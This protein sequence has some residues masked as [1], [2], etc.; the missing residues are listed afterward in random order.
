MGMTVASGAA[1]VALAGYYKSLWSIAWA[2]I[3]VV[4]GATLFFTRYTHEKLEMPLARAVM[5]LWRFPQL[6]LYSIVVSVLQCMWFVG[7]LWCFL[8]LSGRMGTAAD[9]FLFFSLLWLTQYLNKNIYAISGSV[10]AAWYYAL[11]EPRAKRRAPV[12]WPLTNAFKRCSF[13]SLGTVCAWA[14]LDALIKIITVFQNSM[15]VI[16]S[17]RSQCFAVL[18]G[19]VKALFRSVNPYGLCY[20][21]IY[22]KGLHVSSM[23]AYGLIDATNIKLLTADSLLGYAGT[24]RVLCVFASIFCPAV[25]R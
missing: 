3:L 19:L 17:P 11:T 13:Q 5:T 12:R 4:A 24:P 14:T 9:V 6:V 25:Q 18:L 22:G 23:E 7:W 16:M 20:A 10:F 2:L 21:M 15:R 8:K 1:A